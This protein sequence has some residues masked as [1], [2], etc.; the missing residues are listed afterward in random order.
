M[1]IVAVHG[2]NTMYTGTPG[3]P[4]G[5]G[6]PIQSAPAGAS[7]VQSPANGLVVNMTATGTRVATDY[8]WTASAGG[9]CAPT[10][11]KTTT[12][13]FPAPAAGSAQTIT[14]TVAGAGTPPLANGTY[15][16]TVTPIAGVPRMVEQSADGGEESQPE[17]DPQT[18]LIDQTGDTETDTIY[19]ADAYGEF[20]LADHSIAAVKDFLGHYEL[21]D[22]N[23][24]DL[25]SEEEE[26][27][28]RVSL[29]DW[30]N[31]LR[32]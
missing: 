7:A 10:T 11:G 21:T 15:V 4:G 18:G 19:D 28:N 23:I 9:V 3:T 31:T 20:I 1:S 17:V 32:A 8:A 30:L 2:P 26:G 13:T 24:D 22:E 27:A 12:V 14:L 16:T 25:I 29:L 6:T 5:P